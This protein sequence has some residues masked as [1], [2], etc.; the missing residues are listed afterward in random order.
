MG[1]SPACLTLCLWLRLPDET[2]LSTVPLVAEDADGTVAA[3]HNVRPRC[4]TVFAVFVHQVGLTAA[5]AENF[6]HDDR[7]VDDRGGGETG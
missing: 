4:R 2:G 3:L 1:L 7:I 6:K 5:F